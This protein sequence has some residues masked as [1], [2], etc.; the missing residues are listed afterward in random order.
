MSLF[1]IDSETLD[2]VRHSVVSWM[3][4][5]FRLKVSTWMSQDNTEPDHNWAHYTMLWAIKNHTGQSECLECCFIWW[6]FTA[7]P[8]WNWLLFNKCYTVRTL[9]Y[10][11]TGPL[12]PVL[13]ASCPAASQTV[14]IVTNQE[15]HLHI[16]CICRCTFGYCVH[17]LCSFCAF[18]RSVLVPGPIWTRGRNRSLVVHLVAKRDNLSLYVVIMFENDERNVLL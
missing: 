9:Q 10:S 16:S 14:K 7:Y 4:G 3:G 1:R 5:Y 6:N 8:T 17:L 15:K 12:K 13:I 11:R 18:S 2:S